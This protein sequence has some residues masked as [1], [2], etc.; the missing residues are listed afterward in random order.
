[1]RAENLGPVYNV[2]KLAM[3]PAMPKP[4]NIGAQ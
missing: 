1:M 3:E 2:I 4:V